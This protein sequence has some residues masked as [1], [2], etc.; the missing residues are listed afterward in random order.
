MFQSSID[1]FSLNIVQFRYLGTSSSGRKRFKVLQLLL[2]VLQ[3]TILI[4]FILCDHCYDVFPKA[5]FITFNFA[6][7]CTVDSDHLKR[8][9][10]DKLVTITQTREAV[11][12]FISLYFIPAGCLWREANPERNT[13]LLP[14][15]CFTSLFKVFLDAIKFTANSFM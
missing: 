4:Y 11:D 8:K 2:L 5:T 1:H 10:E 7:P 15:S 6:S 3:K 14:F 13:L 12:L 9:D